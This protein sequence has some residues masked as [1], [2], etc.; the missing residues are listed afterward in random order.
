MGGFGLTSLKGGEVY[1]DNI[2][3][4]IIID[5]VR[6]ACCCYPEFVDKKITAP[7]AKVSGYFSLK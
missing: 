1:D 6:D 7:L 3:N 4:Y 2:S 5:I